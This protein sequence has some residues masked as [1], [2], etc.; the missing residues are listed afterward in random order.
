MPHAE[1][2][3]QKLQAISSLFEVLEKNNPINAKRIG[4][5]VM[6]DR[7]SDAVLGNQTD[8]FLMQ[9]KRVQGVNEYAQEL[10]PSRMV[11]A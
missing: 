2:A 10:M 8:A 11:V 6:R 5:V 1:P 4:F 3:N 9:R 7:V